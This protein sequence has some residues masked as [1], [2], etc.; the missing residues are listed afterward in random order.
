M[1]EHPEPHRF[2]RSDRALDELQPPGAGTC[3]ERILLGRLPGSPKKR[4]I[5][6]RARRSL[7]VVQLP[8]IGMQ[9]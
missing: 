6:I 3:R 2:N 9:L 4:R 8:A 1:Q 5:A 7:D